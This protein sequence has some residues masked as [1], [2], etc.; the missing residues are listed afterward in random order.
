MLLIDRSFYEKYLYKYKS[1]IIFS[2]G[3]FCSYVCARKKDGGLF[4]FL[5]SEG[6]VFEQIVEDLLGKL[7]SDK[8]EIIEGIG[9]EQVKVDILHK[10]RKNSEKFEEE[11]GGADVFLLYAFRYM[12]CISEM[13]VLLGII[14]FSNSKEEY[15]SILSRFLMEFEIFLK[16]GDDVKGLFI[17]LCF[18]LNY[19]SRIMEAD[20]DL[21]EVF[22]VSFPPDKVSDG[23]LKPYVAKVRFAILIVL[24]QVGLSKK[25]YGWTETKKLSKLE[26]LVKRYDDRRYD[27]ADEIFDAARRVHV[28][29]IMV[30]A[31]IGEGRKVGRFKY[32]HKD[33]EVDYW[34]DAFLD[35][36]L[37]RSDDVVSEE[38]IHEIA[39]N[40]GIDDE[41]RGG[42]AR[43]DAS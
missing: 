39:K 10:L 27:P 28:F 3:H 7:F 38:E 32:F 22:P 14:D 4:Y 34:V 24:E 33:F 8:S 31:F 36:L 43:Q 16:S 6:D 15:Y 2:F 37:F 20:E 18:S 23:D 11:H 41:T 25:F 9:R 1:F 21:Y 13:A 40:K 30:R 26:K 19:F 29:K 17:A 35:N 42:G 5:Y 12:S